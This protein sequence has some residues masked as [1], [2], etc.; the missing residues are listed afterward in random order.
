ML[1]HITNALAEHPRWTCFLL[2]VVV[3]I[4]GQLD[5]VLP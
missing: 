3:V 2:C 4:A 5:K 1:D